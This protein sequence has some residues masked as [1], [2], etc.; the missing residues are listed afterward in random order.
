MALKDQIKGLLPGW[1]KEPSPDGDIVFS[2]RVRLA[3]NIN[4][5]SF[6]YY[7]GEIQLEEVIDQVG[8]AIKSPGQLQNCV[9]KRLDEMTQLD[10]VL[11]VEKYLVS[12]D[13]IKNPAHRGV[14][15]NQDQ[16]V[17]IMLNEED[18]LRIQSIYS[19][20][21][22]KKAWESATQIDDRL[23]TKLGYAFDEEKG[24]LTTCPTNVGTGLRVS[25][26][27][28]LPAL[29][30]VDQVKK[31]LAVLP[32]VG[33]NVRGAYGEGTDSSGNLYQ[34]SNQVTLG[35]SEEEI[36]SKIVSVTK[37]VIDQERSARDALL[38]NQSRLQLEN[39]VNRAYG[40]LTHSRL[41][42]SEEAVKLLSD[43]LLGASLNLISKV[44]VQVVK[45]LLFLIRPAMLQHLIGKELSPGERDHYRAAVIR[46]H[47]ATSGE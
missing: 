23:E 46:E 35:L 40:L 17:S 28:H 15:L 8:V 39:R 1:L 16:T 38:A 7:A 27:V 47:L 21:Q 12:L 10:R 11:L 6:P 30:M 29:K 32:H 45:E 36:I 13:L 37:Q 33:L 18:H 25:V 2:S 4:Q 41:I 19:G 24:Y 14:V 5:L 43:V 9:L 42:P 26:L 20:L 31:V 44:E 34:I 22:L 3:R